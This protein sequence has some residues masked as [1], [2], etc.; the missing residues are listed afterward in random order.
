VRS[1]DQSEAQII[2]AVARQLLLGFRE[3]LTIAGQLG[4]RPEVVNAALVRLRAECDGC[5]LLTQPYAAE[6]RFVVSIVAW[7]TLKQF[8]SL[9]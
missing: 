2:Q 9:P 5:I 3:S 4:Y 6:A 7:E 1:D 8:G